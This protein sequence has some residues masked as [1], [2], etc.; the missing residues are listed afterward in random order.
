[1]DEQQGADL[2]RRPLEIM[3]DDSGGVVSPGDPG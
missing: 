3:G 2:P 1:M